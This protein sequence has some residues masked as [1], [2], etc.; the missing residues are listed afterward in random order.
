MNQRTEHEQKQD[1]RDQRLDEDCAEEQDSSREVAQVER[2]QGL[3]DARDDDQDEQ[4]SDEAIERGQDLVRGGRARGRG[5]ANGGREAPNQDKS[6]DLSEDEQEHRCPDEHLMSPSEGFRAED[7]QDDGDRADEETSD[8]DDRDPQEQ[9][10][11]DEQRKARLGAINHPVPVFGH[12][13]LD[14][15][16][17]GCGQRARLHLPP[18]D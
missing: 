10:G 2:D 11:E 3:R 9:R 18:R 7:D 4:T 1:H 8:F 15:T 12:L 5:G 14:R 16:R 6:G 13:S 17:R